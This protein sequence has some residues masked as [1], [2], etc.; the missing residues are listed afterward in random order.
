MANL[1]IIAGL[2]N[3]GSDYFGTRHNVGFEVI[4]LLAEHFGVKFRRKYKSRI[5]D[6][7]NDGVKRFLQK[8]MTYMNLSGKSIRSLLSK[9]RLKPSQVLVVYDDLAL[10]LGRM[11][12]R[13]EGGAGGHNGI[14]SII[15]ELGCQEFPRMRIGIGPAPSGDTADFVLER[16]QE[17][18][19]SKL[20]LREASLGGGADYEALFSQFKA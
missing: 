12:I 14:K 10:P 11:R 9:E 3:P 6:I 8:P 5:F 7:E 18:E 13:K 16:F 20:Q 15:N 1:T 17:D 4:D 19:P 2:G